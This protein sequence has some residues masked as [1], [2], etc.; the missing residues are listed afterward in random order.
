MVNRM[1]LARHVAC[2]LAPPTDTL[3]RYSC[4][5]RK[6][7]QLELLFGTAGSGESEIAACLLGAKK[8]NSWHIIVT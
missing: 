8:N 1:M 7:L 3:F 6:K 4:L 5:E 2:I